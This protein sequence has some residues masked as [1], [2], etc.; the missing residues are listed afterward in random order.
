MGITNQEI[1]LQE[2]NEVLFDGEKGFE[3][4]QEK[5]DL[6]KSDQRL[7]QQKI[8]EEFT[9]SSVPYYKKPS[10][11]IASIIL[12]GCPLIWL[13][14]SAFGSS[15]QAAEKKEENPYAQENEQLKVSLDE[16]RQQLEEMNLQA[17]I[18]NQ[19]KDIQLIEP[20]ESTPAKKETEP[21]PKPQPAPV[22]VARTTQ[23]DRPVARIQPVYKAPVV[24]E[25][26]PMEQW[27]AQADRGYSR[28]SFNKPYLDE[29]IASAI[30]IP[31][32]PT[33]DY[34]SERHL[35]LPETVVYSTVETTIAA[36]T[37]EIKP[38]PRT[39]LL[40]ESRL[41]SIR[42]Q[43]SLFDDD[44]LRARL[45]RGGEILASRNNPT[46][47]FALEFQEQIED[48]ASSTENPEVVASSSTPIKTNK[49]FNNVT[50]TK[51]SD[52]QSNSVEILD[53]GSKAKATLVEGIAWTQ[54]SFNQDRKYILYLEEGFENSRGKEVLQSGTR[55][56]AQIERVSSS[57]LFTMK[58]THIV[59]SFN[60]PKIPVPPGTLEI[61][62]KDGSPLQAKL[63]RKGNSDFLSDLGSVVAPGVERALDSST[64]VLVN[65]NFS[66]TTSNSD[67]LTSG[68]SG[69]AK[70]ASNLVRQRTRSNSNRSSTLSY[71][72][73]KG[74]RTVRVVVNDDFYI[75]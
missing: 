73:F 3:D 58:V 32:P 6:K 39:S 71:F 43:P 51:S 8:V 29:A 18:A 31:P 45:N 62:A 57:G 68:L 21:Q 22:K 33:P 19:Q 26:D 42:K 14:W 67:P 10:V 72:Q 63:K 64:N 60:E 17:S 23:P 48:S 35:P 7:L 36:K 4:N 65:D 37:E 5:P 56:I 46:R 9:L 38:I 15:P 12:L 30:P 52:S 20:V 2:A 25:I 50:A 34:K 11:K 53:I 44:Q 61:L 16:A 40:N 1:S 70:G 24:K 74:D 55:L 59:K 47:S 49:D 75:R 69:A 41:T 28:S 27:L 13:V 66:F 54:E